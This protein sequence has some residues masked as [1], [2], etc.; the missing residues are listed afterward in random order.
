[1]QVNSPVSLA[2]LFVLFTWW[3]LVA[4]SSPRQALWRR[5]EAVEGGEAVLPCRLA[6]AAAGDRV[7][8]VL[9]YK[10]N[11]IDPIYSYDNRPG[12]LVGPE[13]RHT[14]RSRLLEGRATF[15]PG[16]LPALHIRPVLRADQANYTCRVDFRIGSSSRR[17]HMTLLVVEPPEP[18]QLRVEGEDWP[19]ANLLGPLQ[20]GGAVDLTCTVV[21]GVPPP[22]VVWRR[23]EEVLQVT[24]GPT[25]DAGVTVSRLQLP[26]VTRRYHNSRLTCLTFN[27]NVT[28]P[29]EASVTL[30][31][32][33]RP[34]LTRLVSP[35]ASL[36][37]GRRY[38]I[39]CM[40]AG[41]RP[42]PNVTWTLSDG[43]A[44][45]Y[46]SAETQHGVNMSSSRVSLRASR[47]HHGQRLSCTALNPL[48]PDHPLADSL[49]LNVTYPPVASL[50]FGRGASSTVREGEDVYF[51]CHVDSNPP[52]YNIT[53]LRRGDPIEHSPEVGVLVG[54]H[55]LA[56]RGVSRHEAGPYV[57]LAS[58]AEGEGASPPLDLEVNYAPVC[59]EDGTATQVY[60]AGIG[61]PVNV[62]CQVKASPPQVKYSW[63][64]NNSISS[65]RLPG[66]Q[67]LSAAGRPERPSACAVVNKTY[68]SL[69]VACEP[70]F[71]GGLPQ[72]FS[73]RV[74]EAMTGRGQVNMSGPHPRFTLEGLT[75][76]LD[77]LIRVSAL[78][79]LGHSPEVRLEAFTYKLA[80]N[81]MKENKVEKKE[82]K[83]DLTSSGV[84]VAV[85]VVVVTAAVALMAALA[86]VVVGA[87]WCLK[88]TRKPPAP[89]RNKGGY[90]PPAHLGRVKT[91]RR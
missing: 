27:N 22:V 63:V 91:R 6:R 39:T 18:P 74:Y 26:H 90:A 4:P 66:E 67:V 89:C 82:Q 9:W 42:H 48:F 10:N 87:R 46:L 45:V 83:T 43:G 15:R 37:V 29:L 33:L 70:G 3:L 38:E 19:P 20:E 80:A 30:S 25:G 65:Q 50:E 85:V 64:F 84:T 86:G 7:Y 72:T 13:Q 61:Q 32:N 41:S 77:Y 69:A 8:V 14:L 55:S 12:R 28:Q 24:Q 73:A 1:M 75:P 54:G 58:N 44:S 23:D 34:L 62:S 31:M 2:R 49:L 88:G 60:T 76:G 11:N 35:P 36:R 5:V 78:N 17:T 47:R 53:W 57:C 51:N 81:T 56:L 40:A 71:D 52:V 79:S 16:Q 68:D 59:V 21:G